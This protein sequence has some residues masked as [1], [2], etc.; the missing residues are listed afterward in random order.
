MPRA[1]N[2]KP[3][4]FTNDNLAE[5]EPLARIMFI[6]LWGVADRE[7]RLLDRP[8]KLKAEILPY[9]NCDADDLLY[10]LAKYGFIT[11]YV[12][13]S[14]AYLQVLN[15]TKHQ[16]PHHKEIASV[17]PAPDGH[18]QITR[19]PYIVPD[20]TRASV[21]KRDANK[22]LKCGTSEQLSI[23]H[24]QSLAKGGDNNINNLQTLCSKCNSAKGVAIKDYRVTNVEP[25]LNQRRANQAT[26]CPSESLILNPEPPILKTE[27]MQSPRKLELESELEVELQKKKVA[28]RLPWIDLPFE[29]EP[30]CQEEMTWS[31]EQSHSAFKSFYEY[32]NSADC[33]T[34]LRKDWFMAF[35]NSCR[36]GITK[37][38]VNLKRNTN[39]GKQKDYDGKLAIA[40][41]MCEAS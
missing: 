8:K 41:G 28:I 6:G 39:H 31:K 19:H 23:D 9:D 4:F 3:A 40:Q 34:P 1:R 25:T 38:N 27:S 15:F 36:N 21:F 10:Q 30:F 17:I 35:K 33:K 13:E 18:P 14:T 5:C 16:M 37:P 12:I 2:I 22:C 7:G 29:W 11:R 24:I 32:N 26:S 20:K